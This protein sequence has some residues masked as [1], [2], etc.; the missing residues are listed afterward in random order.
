MIRNSRGIAIMFSGGSHGVSY[1]G[2][3]RSVFVNNG[4]YFLR[5]G[6]NKGDRKQTVAFC[7]G[8]EQNAGLW[9]NRHNFVRSSTFTHNGF[10]NL[11]I[12]EQS[13]FTAAENKINGSNNG[14]GI[15]CA[16][17]S[18]IRIVRNIVR[19]AA[20]N[21][22]DCFKRNAIVSIAQKDNSSMNGDRQIQADATHCGMIAKNKTMNNFHS[23]A[24]SWAIEHPGAAPELPTRWRNHYRRRS[25][26]DC[27]ECRRDDFRATYRAT[28]K[29]SRPTAF[30][31]QRNTASQRE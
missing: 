22:I 9:G 3:E 20:G 24:P 29:I 14:A 7:C 16:N 27:S 13:W 11:S 8:P 2:V 25:K 31:I 23:S 30:G 12:S 21:G 17:N 1:S 6:N 28:M 19:A 10:D 26:T 5:S 4:V 15:Y 18:H